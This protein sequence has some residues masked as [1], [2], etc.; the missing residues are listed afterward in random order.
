MSLNETLRILRQRCNHQLSIQLSQRTPL[1][2]PMRYAVLNGGKR[3]RPIFV[4]L[5]GSML[6][7]H[8]EQLDRPACAIELMHSYSLVH[9]DLPAMDNAQ[10]RRGQATCHRYYDETTAILVGDALQTHAFTLLS[11]PNQSHLSSQ[12]RLDMLHILAESSGHLG[13]ASGQAIDTAKNDAPK[14]L[15]QLEKC[16]ALKTGRL[17]EA[18]IMMGA[19]AAQTKSQAKLDALKTFAAHLGLMY[20]VVDD[21]LDVQGTE[22]ST[23]KSTQK[24]SEKTT[25]VDFL[26]LTGAKDYAKDLT[27]KAI[28]ALKPFGPSAKDM[29]ALTQQL[30]L[31]TH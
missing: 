18:T 16:H 3:L 25:F 28:L 12:Q 8:L 2:E 22:Q 10:L 13:M 19:I 20:Q 11:N 21:V 14:T 1:T 9:D 17:F 5:T 29:I 24:D 7:A 4:Y 26:G 31:R 15:T 27:H 23:G 6:N 30:S